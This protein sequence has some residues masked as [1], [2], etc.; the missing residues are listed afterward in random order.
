LLSLLVLGSSAFAQATLTPTTLPFGK[1]GVNSTSAAKT[2]TLT[3]N[4]STAITLSGET[5]TGT[6]ASAFAISAK[7]CGASLAAHA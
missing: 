3:N 1:Q 2:V 6:N 5:I 4:E 7:T